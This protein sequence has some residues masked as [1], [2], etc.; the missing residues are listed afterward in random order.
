MRII[1][2]LRGTG[3]GDGGGSLTIIKSANILQELNNE[4]F[5]IDS[6]KN[7]HTWTKLKVPHIISKNDNDIPYSDV[8]IATGFDSVKYTLKAPLKCGKKFHWIRGF[9]LWRMSEKQI[10][11]DVLNQP[12]TKIVNSICLQNKLN[13]Y[14]C[15]SIICRPGHDF[16]SL[17]FNG[18]RNNNDVIC[19][20]GLY[21]TKHITKRTN[22]IIN[23]WKQLQKKYPNLILTMFGT[24]SF[25]N[26]NLQIDR[27]F[28]NPDID[29]KNSIYNN[30]D[31]FLSPSELEGLHIVPAEAMLCECCI[32]GTNAEM[33]GTQDYLI[34]NET[35]IVSKNNFIDFKNCIENILFNKKLINKL[36]KNGR[37]KILDMGDRKT[38]MKKMIDILNTG[39]DIIKYPHQ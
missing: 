27:Y 39:G 28:Q 5:I 34:N 23:S 22:W 13:K 25:S 32:I 11:K 17:Y 20:G 21:N 35:G 12:T 2:D 1:F 18:E 6:G 10:I 33:S 31:I 9:E 37:K 3:L 16:D 24:Q 19:L 8:I 4:V 30:I 15:K 38:N 7:Q 29:I 14:N 36:G 26:N